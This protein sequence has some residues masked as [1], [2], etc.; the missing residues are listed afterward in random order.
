MYDN[1]SVALSTLFDHVYNDV[2]PI[3]QFSKG[4]GF[5]SFLNGNNKQRFFVEV[6]VNNEWYIENDR[7]PWQIFIGCTQG[8]TTGVV[9][10]AVAMHQLTMVE[11]D[12][13]GWIF[14]VTDQKHEASILQNG[15]RRFGRD[16]LHFMFDNDGSTGYIRK[17]AGTVPPRHYSSTRYCV[18]KIYSLLKEGYDLFLT[19]NGVILIYD[20]LPPQ[21]F[22]VIDQ[23]PYIGCNCFSK[24]SGHG[25]PPGVRAGVW[26]PGMTALPR[27]KEYLSSDEISKYLEDDQLVEYRVPRNPFPKRRQTAWEFMG[28]DTPKLFL[29]MLDNFCEERRHPAACDINVPSSSASAEV[30]GT[31]AP[32]AETLTGSTPVEEVNIEAEFSTLNKIE[33]QSV[34]IITENPWHLYTSGILTLRDSK[35]ER[36]LNPF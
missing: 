20:D 5:S 1:G 23:F 13:F 36:V 8:H 22:V 30:F 21:F 4:R 11:L 33:L 28:Q 3:V 24:T 31:E 19:Q 10:P 12:S 27:Y 32:A 17:G 18:L 7:L 15:L 25:L 29:K 6:Y 9:S 26:R 14:H 35:G 34:Q 2:N 16:S